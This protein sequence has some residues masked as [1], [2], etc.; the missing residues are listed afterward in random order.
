[1][2]YN[3]RRG[4]RDDHN[5]NENEINNI[6]SKIDEFEKL[7]DMSVKE[8]ADAEGYADIIAKNSRQLKTNQ[9]RKF[10]GAVRLMEQKETWEEIE[11]EFYLLKPRLAVSAGRKNIPKPFYNLIMST[12]RK[13]DIGS[14]EEKMKNFK[15]FVAFFESIVAYHKY[16]EEMKDWA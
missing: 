12:M 13:V 1:M 4:R 6:I 9:L 11:P 7:C 3:N 10:F 5:N 16:H 15:T 14:E 2:A 8:F